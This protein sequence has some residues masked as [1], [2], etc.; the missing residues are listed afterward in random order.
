MLEIIQEITGY[1]S[2]VIRWP[3]SQSE[4]GAVRRGRTTGHRRRGAPLSRHLQPFAISSW[5]QPGLKNN[6]KPN[7][8]SAAA[9]PKMISE[10]V[11]S[12]QL[13]S[14]ASAVDREDVMSTVQAC[15]PTDSLQRPVRR[16]GLWFV[17][18][19]EKIQAFVPKRTVTDKKVPRA[20]FDK[21]LNLD[22]G[23]IRQ[24]IFVFPLI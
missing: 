4:Q 21:F 16:S 6:K 19:I 7:E 15:P 8:Q 1:P 12:D 24:E 13:T 23:S 22:L 17:I 2:K 9:K 14:D 11:T 3:Q 5:C 10:N 18:T 20:D